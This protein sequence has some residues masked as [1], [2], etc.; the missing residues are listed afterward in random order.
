MQRADVSLA[1]SKRRST[2]WSLG[3]LTIGE[4]K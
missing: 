4:L 3:K 2:L 1:E